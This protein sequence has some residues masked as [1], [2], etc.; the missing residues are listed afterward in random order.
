MNIEERGVVVEERGGTAL[1]RASESSHCS[2][3]AAAGSCRGGAGKERVV[4]ALNGIGAREGD[5]VLMAV[6]SG[7]LLKA[8]FQV[9]MVPV[10]GILAGAGAAQAVAGALA[11]PEAAAMAAGAGG[12]T[13]AVLAVAG[14]RLFR[15]RHPESAGLRPRITRIV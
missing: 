5:E 7:A 12:L 13:G 2:G 14:T 10:L 1:V 9:Y 3:C 4:E 15:R 11:G 6:P 8:S